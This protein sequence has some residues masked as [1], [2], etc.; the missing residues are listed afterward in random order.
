[1]GKT[2]LIADDEPEIVALLRL[3]LEVEGYS[4]VEASNGKEALAY[5]QNISIDLAV[6]DIMMPEL[7]GYQL[8]KL[9]R[10]DYKLPIIILSA[11][12]QETDKILGLG[13][14][15][16]DFISKPFSSMEVLARVQ[17]QLRRTYEFNEA[18]SVALDSQTC[19]GDMA[20][21]HHSCM[22]Y[23]RGQPI[24]L[25]SIEYKLLKLFMDAPGRIYT[26]KQI[27]EKA[28]SDQYFADD[29]TIMVQ[30][31]RLRDKIEDQPRNPMYIKTIR[32]LGYRFAKKDELDGK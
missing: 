17:A 25:S 3:F 7:D 5:I 2:I 4:V 6:I 16:D 11:K 10:K 14:G 26:K 18:D 12:N 13:I 20:L 15:A 28:W 21:D 9:I 8:I 32:G 30:I 27:F 23:K 22:L 1:M 24:S 19:V 29:N 31:S